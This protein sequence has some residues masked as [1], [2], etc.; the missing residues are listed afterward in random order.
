M[1]L[2]LRPYQREAVDSL[3]AWF[4]ENH[5][6]NPLVV[7][8]TAGGKSLIIATFVKEAIEAWPDTRV[9]VLTHVKELI[10]QNYAELIGFWPDA[11]AGIYSAGLGKRDLRSRILFAGIQS[12]HRRAYDLQRVDLVLVDEAHLIPRSTETT[13]GRF[14]ADL[15]QI[16]PHMR[17]VGFTATPFRL[18]SGLLH[19]GDGALFRSVAYEAHMR[20]LI[21]QSY[22]CP[23]ISGHTL[24]RINTDGIR[25]VAGEFNASQLE[26][27]ATD[28]DA[29]AGIVREVVAAGQ[30]RRGWIVFGVGLEHCTM[31]RDG[32][33]AAG[34][35]CEAIFG[36]TLPGER[37]RLVRDFKAQRIRCLVSVGVL[38]TGF[39]AKHVDLIALARPT[40]STSL[41][42]QMIGRGTRLSPGKENCL[43]LDFGGNIERHG[44]VDAPRVKTPGEGGGEMPT[45]KCEA[46][47]V[48]GDWYDGCGADNLIAAVK[49][50]GCGAPFPRE[51]KVDTAASG[52]AILTS[53]IQPEW[54]EVSSVSYRRH[55]K[56]GKP[57]SLCVTYMCGFVAHREWVCLEHTGIPRAKAVSWWQKR[58]RSGLVPNTVNEALV[59]FKAL[60]KPA[61]I[62]VRPV[63]KFTEIVG[64]RFEPAMREVA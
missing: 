50:C 45:K 29:V 49:C 42:V 52:H 46:R 25:T 16:N 6:G 34:I 9:I 41:Y 61:A 48:A 43:I 14:L 33:R 21:E 13:Y 57:A 4:E 38:T 37:D 54:V 39:N 36:D 58:T 2:Q 19:E 44:P 15:L 20:D 7:I 30:D 28:P 3:G 53:H 12:I 17:V 27:A 51:S 60:A 18:D 63:G 64:T 23:P 56:P 35:S 47:T 10:A 62:Q 26:A 1:S 11:P 5:D 32:I 22:L 59:A 24:A 40:K 31:L 55:E 8:P